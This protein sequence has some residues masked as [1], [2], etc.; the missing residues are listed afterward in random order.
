MASEIIQTIKQGAQIANDYL[1]RNTGAVLA[2]AGGVLVGTA[3]GAGVAAAVGKGKTASVPSRKRKAKKGTRKK[4]SRKTRRKSRPSYARTA[5]KGKD[6][7]TKRIRMTKNG[8]PYVIMKSG[9]ARFIKKTSARTSR[10]R[11]GGRY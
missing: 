8:Q 5:G 10:R 3:L 11:K 1:G 4:A 6:R 7:S 9:K 2:G